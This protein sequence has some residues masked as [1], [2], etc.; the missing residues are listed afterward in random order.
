MYDHLCFFT[1][2][3]QYI[4]YM[5]ITDPGHSPLHQSV[6]GTAH[7]VAC[8]RAVHSPWRYTRPMVPAPIG[9]LRHVGSS[10]ACR[11]TCSPQRHEAQQSI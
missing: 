4:Q 9:N 8:C 7:R 2:Y 11:K 3:I 10:K 5:Y 1:Q 6:M